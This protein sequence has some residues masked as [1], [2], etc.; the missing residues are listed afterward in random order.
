MGL[1]SRNKENQIDKVMKKNN[2]TRE[3]LENIKDM[4]ITIEVNDANRK[5]VDKISHIE[6]MMVTKGP[7]NMTAGEIL[8]YS[9][10]AYTLLDALLRLSKSIYVTVQSENGAKKVSVKDAISLIINRIML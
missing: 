9:A 2:I 8:Q 1:F 7:S 3:Q 4:I 6:G 10:S 5:E